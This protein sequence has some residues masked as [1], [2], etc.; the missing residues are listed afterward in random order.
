MNIL[1]S[2]KHLSTYRRCNQV[3]VQARAQLHRRLPTEW[4]FQE[5]RPQVP[6]KRLPQVPA[7]WSQAPLRRHLRV[8]LLAFQVPADCCWCS[9]YWVSG[10][11]LVID[12]LRQ[13]KFYIYQGG[14]LPW[15]LGI[16]KF[17]QNNLEFRTKF[18]KILE[19]LTFIK[20]LLYFWHFY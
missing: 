3:L 6:V 9:L 11:K 19:F 18:L 5:G 8:P 15:K 2:T 20:T 1:S 4:E 7:G 12:K 17:R 13:D 16:W 14:H 10:K